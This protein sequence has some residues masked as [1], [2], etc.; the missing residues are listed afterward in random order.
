VSEAVCLDD[1]DGNGVELCRDG[2]KAAWPRAHDGTLAMEP[3]DLHALP[4]E[5]P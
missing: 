4:A 3:P 1:P 2:P 5:R